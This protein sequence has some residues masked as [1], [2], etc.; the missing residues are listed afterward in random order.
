[1]SFPFSF[2]SF[3]DVS[4]GRDPEREREERELKLTERDR[5][6]AE[7]ERERRRGDEERRDLRRGERERDL[8]TQY[9]SFS[10]K[11]YVLS[12]VWELP[13]VLEHL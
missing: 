8:Q 11:H 12:V 1:M 2:F 10:Q 9:V 7:L 6:E 4:A 5:E 13:R 3:R